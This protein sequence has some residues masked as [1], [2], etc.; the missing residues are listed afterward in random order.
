MFSSVFVKKK[1]HKLFEGPSVIKKRSLIPKSNST[2]LITLAQKVKKSQS[3][4]FGIKLG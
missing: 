3:I 1:K 4:Y 2:V